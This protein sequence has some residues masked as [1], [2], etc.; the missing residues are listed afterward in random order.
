MAVLKPCEARKHNSLEGRKVQ[1]F[2]RAGCHSSLAHG[3]RVW[4]SA[5]TLPVV[6]LGLAEQYL[7]SSLHTLRG[8]PCFQ[9]GD[10]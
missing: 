9:R 5:Q 1:P 3:T 4:V 2:V 10:L 6:Y 8:L 7:L